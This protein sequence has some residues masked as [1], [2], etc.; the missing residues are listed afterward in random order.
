[1]A[2]Q[3]YWT[4]SNGRQHYSAP[5]G[6]EY[7]NFPGTGWQR[8]R[9]VSEGPPSPWGAGFPSGNIPT[10][11]SGF[12]PVNTGGNT[13]MPADL[14]YTPPGGGFYDPGGTF[15]GGQPTGDFGTQYGG[16]NN[17]LSS[18]GG[19]TLI[20]T[21]GNM[22]TGYLGNRS[23]AQAQQANQNEIE[24][25]IRLALMQLEPA[26]I[27]ALMQSLL[28]QL[29]SNANRASQ[30]AIQGVRE[31][32]ARIGLGGSPYGLSFEAGTRA[33]LFGDVQA[34]AL[35]GALNLAGQRASAVSGA[36]FVPIQ[37][38]TGYAE[39]LGQSLNQGFAAYAL[40]RRQPTPYAP[41]RWPGTPNY[42][43]DPYS[44]YGSPYDQYG[45][46]R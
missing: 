5:D 36:P 4:D 17:F 39:A 3:G 38:R 7:V 23:Q 8:I 44:G 22:F 31:Q 12:T 30:T 28:P 29:M 24:H 34:Q 1:M 33:K 40:S 11:P 14:G 35:T 27:S 45:W 15:H 37:P 32:A 18:F 46:R 16:G 42:G 26:Q 6:S 10:V 41:Y 9:P 21:L 19:Q 20:N 2:N 13:N 25:R 43:S